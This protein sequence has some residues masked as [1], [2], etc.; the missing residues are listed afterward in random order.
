MRRYTK[1][2][3]LFIKSLIR[4]NIE[5]AK[6]VLSKKIDIDPAIVKLHTNC[7]NDF[8]KLLVSNTITLTPGTITMKLEDQNLYIHILDLKNKSKDE[9]QKEI[10]D[11][12]EDIILK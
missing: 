10:V 12:F 5:V 7:T 9:L 3:L 11:S 4:S 6:I 2:T 8:D 1:F